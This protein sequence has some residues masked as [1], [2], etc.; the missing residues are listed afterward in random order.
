MI[1]TPDFDALYRDD[2]DPWRVASSFYE[3]R[4]LSVLLASLTQPTYAA[5]WDPASGTGAL[6]LRLADR[7]EVVLA[8]DSSAEAVRLT[9]STCAGLPNVTVR[10]LRQPESP[11][12]S[13]AGL[14]LLVVAEFAYYLP[15]HDRAG[16]WRVVSDAA[17]TSAEIVVVHWRHR[18]H[19]G[20]L[21][22]ADVQIEAIQ[23]LT[24]QHGWWPS[25][26]HDDRDFVLDVLRRG[27]E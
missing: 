7:A 6:A 11:G 5:A 3:Q 27:P 17:A 10:R 14:D 22:G 12:E 18:P 1:E 2:P 19:D 21:S 4:K 25:V 9:A 24:T 8:T 23:Q 13:P 26:Q 15:P 20:Y 16:L